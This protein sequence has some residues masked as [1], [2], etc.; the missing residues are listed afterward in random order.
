MNIP[1]DYEEKDVEEKL[2]QPYYHIIQVK[3]KLN[4]KRIPLA[5]NY[6]FKLPEQ[7]VNEIVDLVNMLNNGTLI[8]D[9]IQDFTKLRRTIPAAH[10]IYG[11][12]LC[13]N[14][15][16]HVLFLAVKK[17]L[18]MKDHRVY[19]IC[20]EEMLDLIRGQ[21]IDI[22]WRDT[23]TC[24]SVEDYKLACIQK[25]CS[26]FS[27]PV[28]LLQHFSEDKRDYK[29]LIQLISLYFQ[30]RDDYCNL[31]KPEALEDW[32]RQNE[33]VPS[34][35]EE[36]FCEDI[37]EGKFSLPVIHAMQFLEG[38]GVLN[39]LKLRTEDRAMKK[40]CVSLLHKLGSM[41]YT[42]KVLEEMHREVENE[43]AR[44]GGNPLL[45]EILKELLTWK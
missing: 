17:L 35:K 28:R 30:I 8:L 18:D 5:F 14:T 1:K 42:R 25:T 26:M 15:S 40:Y 11:I 24:P 19:E 20:L 27:L 32:P 13:T 43:I 38:V 23:H 4:K 9:D 34:S 21:G 31:N 7:K 44:L 37:T 29:R 45:D 33:N 41:E 39:I 10:L 2:L 12:P 3:G 6:W 36:L 22:Y 16:V